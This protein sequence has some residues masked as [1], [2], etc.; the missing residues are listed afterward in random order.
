MI[1]VICVI[2]FRLFQFFPYGN[3][4]IPGWKDIGGMALI[5]ASANWPDRD[6]VVSCPFYGFLANAALSLVKVTVHL[7]Q[8]LWLVTSSSQLL[9]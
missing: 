4:S 6:G 3:Q 5:T 8:G 9:Q 2:Q 7:H 1:G